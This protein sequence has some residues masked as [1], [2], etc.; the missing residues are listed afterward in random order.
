M[1]FERSV[2]SRVDEIARAKHFGNVRRFFVLPV[3]RFIVSSGSFQKKKKKQ[4]PP[5]T[6]TSDPLRIIRVHR[7]R[8]TLV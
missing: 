4:K 2:H 8:C 3:V 1:V 5:R 6:T 7:G